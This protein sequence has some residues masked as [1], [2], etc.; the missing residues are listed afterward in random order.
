MKDNNS[1]VIV[2]GGL[3]GSLAA[4]NF[5]KQGV[6]VTMYEQGSDMRAVGAK[7]GRSINLAIITRGL[8]ALENI[9]FAQPVTEAM[10]PMVGRMVHIKGQ[11]EP[12]CSAY[13][14]R[15]G[16]TNNSISRAGLNKMLL[17]EAEKAGV[18]IMFDHKCVGYDAG[19]KI[20]SFEHKG[21]V[22]TVAAPVVISAE[23]N[24]MSAALHKAIDEKVPGNYTRSLF[25]YEYKEL[26]IPPTETGGFRLDKDRLHIWPSGPYMQIALPN[27][28]GSFTCTLFLPHDGA[29]TLGKLAESG[30]IKGFFAD[31]FPHALEHIPDLERDFKANPVGQM[32]TV[33]C[34][35]WHLG[36]QLLL[37]GDAA[38]GVVPFHGQGMNGG[39]ED[40]TALASALKRNRIGNLVNWEKVFKELQVERKVNTDALAR[41]SIANFE[42]MKSTADELAQRRKTIA[43]DLERLSEQEGPLKG[44]CLEHYTMMAFCPGIAYS[45]VEKRDNALNPIIDKL[46][47]E[48]ISMKEATARIVAH[49]DLQPLGEEVRGVKHKSAATRAGSESRHWGRGQ[50]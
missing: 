47:R 50:R 45:V 27:Q 25:E 22:K 40:C 18:K 1:V 44:R 28:D 39:F 32:H 7:G 14:Q 2:G 20:L 41:Q 48:E 30:K 11:E 34:K 12:I 9:G 13:S 46:A 19:D 26:R 10:V 5:A 29:V 21:E 35:Q 38:H 42:G 15:E 17:T 6:K 43:F 4:I 16:E 3:V 36:G 24:S 33:D 23:G 8:Q 49:P 37:I 31:H